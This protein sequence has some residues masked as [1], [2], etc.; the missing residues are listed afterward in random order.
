MNSID[1]NYQD[2][3]IQSM[4]N[5]VKNRLHYNVTDNTL[6][7]VDTI[8]T[9]EFHIWWSIFGGTSYVKINEESLFSTRYSQYFRNYILNDLYY[10]GYVSIENFHK[11]QNTSFYPSLKV[12]T[13]AIKKFTLEYGINREKKSAGYIW[14]N[15]LEIILCTMVVE[16]FFKQQEIVE[17]NENLKNREKSPITELISEVVL[18]V[19]K[20]KEMKKVLEENKESNIEEY[21]KDN[22]DLKTIYER[23]GL[24]IINT[25][26]LPPSTTSFSIL[27][28]IKNETEKIIS[29]PLVLDEKDIEYKCILAYIDAIVEDDKQLIGYVNMSDINIEILNMH[30]TTYYL[31]LIADTEII[32][33]DNCNWYFVLLDHNRKNVK[34]NSIQYLSGTVEPPIEP[35]TEK[36]EEKKEIVKEKSENY[37][38]WNNYFMGIAKLVRMRSKD[39]ACKVGA[40]I[41]RDNKVL[42]TGYNGFP[43]GLSDKDYPWTKGS[44]DPTK[45]KYFYVVHAELNAILN[46]DNPVNGSTLFVTKFPCNECV[47]A[48]IQAGIKRVVF[49]DEIQDKELISDPLIYTAYKM[50]SDAGITVERYQYI[51]IGINI[52]L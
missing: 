41:V 36:V 16:K 33:T 27:K 31:K 47:K 4:K 38:S 18:A 1:K 39:P 13:D 21:K 40:C 37:I 30:N 43:I 15:N 6:I 5:G 34:V 46:S 19:E 11:L 20:D 48:I 50:L 45:N 2:K 10:M 23:F 3:I 35:D 24:N 44:E 7:E 17:Q 8:F 26:I 22:N 52:E 12:F 42:S 51:N 9:D 25:M 28:K 29:I 14:T 49:D 32:D